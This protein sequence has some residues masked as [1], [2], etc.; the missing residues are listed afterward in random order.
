MV[1]CC[2]LMQLTQCRKNATTLVQWRR[3]QGATICITA[4]ELTKRQQGSSLAESYLA[5]GVACKTAHYKMRPLSNE[6]THLPGISRVQAD[7]EVHIAAAYKTA[8]LRMK[9]DGPLQALQQLH[10]AK[11]ASCDTI[12]TDTIVAAGC[13]TA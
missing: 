1:A 5:L 12:Q 7:Q 8:H 13:K 2:K 10:S 6:L 4:P 11:P 3:Q 9:H